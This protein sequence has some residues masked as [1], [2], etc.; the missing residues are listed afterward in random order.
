MTQQYLVCGKCVLTLEYNNK[1]FKTLFMVAAESSP[2]L[3][4][5]TCNK[6][7]L[8]K[9]MYTYEI[10]TVLNCTNIIN[11]FD[12]CFGE[13]GC[14][15]NREY[16]IELCDD[17]KPVISPSRKIPIALKDKLNNE[18][19]HM[20]KLGIEKIHKLTEWLNTL[21]LIEKPNGKLRVCLERECYQLPTVT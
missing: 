2:L 11:E 18:L 21:V 16:P 20:E 12:D 6:L 3:G 8:I 7:N 15:L 13:I 5:K 4:L 1:T 14:L 19:R 9:R 10:N 17:V